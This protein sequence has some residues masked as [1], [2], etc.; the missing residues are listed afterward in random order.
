MTKP[1]DHA[2][3]VPRALIEE[4]LALASRSPSGVNTQPWKLCVLHSGA[5]DTLVAQLH[6]HLPALC[7]Q[8]DLQAAFWEQFKRLPGRV[9]WPGPAWESAGDRFPACAN[10]AFGGGALATEHD[11]NQY[12][13]L[14]GAPTALVCTI[15]RSLGLGSVLD[16]GMFV[17]NVVMAAAAR[18]LDCRSMVGWKGFA[19]IVLG[20]VQAPAGEVLVTVLALGYCDSGASA[21]REAVPLSQLQSSAF[22][23]W[24]D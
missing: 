17:Q 8:A 2:R 4:I 22:T 23:S 13:N 21:T 11:L 18:G 24:R 16:Y 3:I 6:A 15:D 10:A 12:F 14:Y 20:H 5:R 7:S 19:D 9:N 1:Y